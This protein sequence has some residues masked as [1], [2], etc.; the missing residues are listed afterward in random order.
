ME[1]IKIDLNSYKSDKSSVFTGRPQGKSVRE[2]LNLD[3]YD[4]DKNTNV[5]FTIPDNTSSFNPSFYLGLLFPSYETLGIDK[6]DEKYSFE[7]LTNNDEI[8]KV[9]N[10]D[11]LDGKRS[12]INSMKK[13]SK[14]F[15]NFFK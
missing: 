5:V 14:I 10:S 2:K 1:T 13:S 8:T 6:F 9:I 4:K 12:A 7:I 11:L 3:K 15:S